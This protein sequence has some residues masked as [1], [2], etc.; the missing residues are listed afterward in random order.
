MNVLTEG[1]QDGYWI[2]TGFWSGEPMADFMLGLPSLAIH[3]Q[4]FDGNTTGRRWK[5]FRP[6][7]EDNWKVGKSL[8]LNLGLGWALTTPIGEV[9]NR[10]ADFNPANGQFLVAGQNAGSSAGIQFDKTD[11]EPR[12]GLAWKP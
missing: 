12:V 9:A 10:Q 7:V 11:L 6:Y 3:D 5:L 1:F 2:M 4:T 8:T